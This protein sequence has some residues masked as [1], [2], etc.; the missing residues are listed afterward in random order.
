M[1]GTC[2]AG[3]WEEEDFW[4]VLHS[5]QRRNSRTRVSSSSSK[6]GSRSWAASRRLCF[7]PSH[8]KLRQMMN[9]SEVTTQFFERHH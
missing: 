7:L 6:W 9:R 5:S 4:L 8:R 2:S 3:L 1:R